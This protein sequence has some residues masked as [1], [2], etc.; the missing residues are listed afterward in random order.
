M[1]VDIHLA[2]LG[3]K[4]VVSTGFVVESHVLCRTQILREFLGNMPTGVGVG[5]NLKTIDL[6]TLSG[7]QNGI[8]RTLRTIEHNCLSTLEEGNLLDF[9][10]KHVV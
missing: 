9:R 8:L 6:T 5:C 7:N 1:V 10:G 4:S 2:V 3:I